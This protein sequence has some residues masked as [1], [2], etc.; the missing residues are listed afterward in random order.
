MTLPYK[1]LAGTGT[2]PN[3]NSKPYPA[4]FDSRFEFPNRPVLVE[5][6]LKT[7]ESV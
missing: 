4:I 6:N 3:G 5:E 1:S 7:K 2:I